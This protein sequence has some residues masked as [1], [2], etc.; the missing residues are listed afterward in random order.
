METMKTSRVTLLLLAVAL[1]LSSC[2][3]DLSIHGNGRLATEDRW[4]APFNK[5]KVTGEYNVFIVPGDEYTVEVTAESNLLGHIVTDRD[6]DKLKI[7]TRGINN[8]HHT[9]PIEIYITTPHLNQVSL[10][11]PG[12]IQTENFTTNKFEVFLSGSGL[13]ES[14]VETNELEANLSGSGEIRLSGFCKHSDLLISGSGKI[15]SYGME[16]ESCHATISGSGDILV[17]AS[18]WIEAKISGSGDLL[19]INWP[20]ISSNISGSGKVIND[21]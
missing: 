15:Q 12:L 4:V 18:D 8:L 9:I 1:M 19:F 10:S 7:R 20:E 11:G 16:Q 5:V 21:N 17:N 14:I 3:E 2:L 13:I 6:G